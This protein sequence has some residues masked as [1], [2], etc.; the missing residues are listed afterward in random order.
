MNWLINPRSE[1][2]YSHSSE[3]QEMPKEYA[4]MESENPAV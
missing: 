3:R 1:R 4:I 2:N